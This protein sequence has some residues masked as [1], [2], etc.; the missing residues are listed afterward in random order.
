MSRDELL[1]YYERELRFIRKMA[2]EFAEKYPQVGARLQLEPTK[3]EDPHV[4]RLI[5]A[6]AMLTARVHLRLDDDFSDV[7]DALLDIIY[8]HYLRPIPSMTIVQMH[9]DPD[10]G[11]VEGGLA[12]PR[13]SMLHSRPRQHARGLSDFFHSRF[14]QQSMIQQHPFV[15]DDEC[16]IAGE[17][18]AA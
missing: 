15:T 14:R 13:H 11:A 5:E 16:S 6:F 18:V 9:V 7:T 1:T 17:D 12:V 10:E 8:P 2:T 3:C 4:E